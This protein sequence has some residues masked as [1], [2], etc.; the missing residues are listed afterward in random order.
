MKDLKICSA[1]FYLDL[2]EPGDGERDD[3][4]DNQ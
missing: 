4:R 3:K 1:T 2:G